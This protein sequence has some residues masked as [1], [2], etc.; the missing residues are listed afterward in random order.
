MYGA[1][2]EE[3]RPGRWD[4]DLPL[5][6]DKVSTSWGYLPFNGGP[7]VCLGRMDEPNPFAQIIKTPLADLL[8]AHQEEFALAEASYTIVRI[9]QVFPQIRPAIDAHRPQKWIGWSSHQTEGIE[10]FTEK[11]QKMTLVLSSG[12]GCI[13]ALSNPRTFKS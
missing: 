11:K 1:D 7:R 9:L 8:C 5:F 3:F 12:D 6:R 4:E 2:A 13:V 10:K